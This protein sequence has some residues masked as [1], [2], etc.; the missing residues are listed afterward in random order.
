[1]QLGDLLALAARASAQTERWLA[2]VDGAFAQK[3]RDEAGRRGETVAQFLRIAA[4]DFTAAAD[5]EAW[6]DLVSAVRDARDPGLACVAKMAAFRI[7]LE[8]SP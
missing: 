8:G 7:R 3:V 1:V 6:A 2:A 4:S 5:E